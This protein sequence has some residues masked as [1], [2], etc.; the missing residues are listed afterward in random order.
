MS[1]QRVTERKLG[2]FTSVDDRELKMKIGFD[3]IRVITTESR[4]APRKTEMSSKCLILSAATVAA[5][6]GK[7]LARI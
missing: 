2:G 5:A 1:G 6:K 3:L 4:T 7:Q